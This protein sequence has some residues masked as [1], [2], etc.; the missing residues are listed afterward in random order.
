MKKNKNY[1]TQ[2][3]LVVTVTILLMF[4]G[5]L[6][7]QNQN[8]EVQVTGLVEDQ[9]GFPIP[10]ANVVIENIRKGVVTDF[11]GKFSISVPKGNV[12]SISFIGMVTQKRVITEETYLSIVMQN[13]EE[14]LENVVVKRVP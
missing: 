4:T 8:T 2:L 11:D 5:Q 14:V 1:T 6:R 3:M 13:D 7:S 12:L 10:G 9:E